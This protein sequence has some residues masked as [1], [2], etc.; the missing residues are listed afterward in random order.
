MVRLSYTANATDDAMDNQV[1]N[2]YG[3]LVIISAK[4]DSMKFYYK[5]N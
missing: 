5:Q 1:N 3:I 4:N 2:S